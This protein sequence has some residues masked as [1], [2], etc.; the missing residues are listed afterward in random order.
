MY[1]VYRLQS[2]IAS[3]K[4]YV[5]FS[6]DIQK[7]LEAHNNGQ[8]AHTSKYKP[9]KIINYIAFENE[10]KAR[11]FEKYLKGGSGRAFSKKHF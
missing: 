6:A 4:I 1:Y 9:W 3:S 8:N 2:L 11:D 7:R 5:G 10:E